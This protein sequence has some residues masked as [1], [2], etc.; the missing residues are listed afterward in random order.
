MALNFA[1]QTHKRFIDPVGDL[2]LQRADIVSSFI[3][4]A[5]P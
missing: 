1:R 2:F 4:E 3:H 5:R